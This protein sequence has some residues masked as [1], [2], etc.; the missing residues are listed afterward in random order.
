VLVLHRG[1]KANIHLHTAHYSLAAWLA[2]RSMQCRRAAN[3]P[4]DPWEAVS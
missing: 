2:Q 1:M 4:V 3:A